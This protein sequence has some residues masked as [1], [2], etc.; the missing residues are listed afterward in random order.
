MTQ[1]LPPMNDRVYM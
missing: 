1:E